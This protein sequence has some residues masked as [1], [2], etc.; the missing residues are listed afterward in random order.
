MVAATTEFVVPRSMPTA[1]AIVVPPL[2]FGWVL[3]WGDRAF[4][5]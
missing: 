5:R 4:G 3:V 2:V 1:F